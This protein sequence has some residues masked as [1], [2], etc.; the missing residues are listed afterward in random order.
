MAAGF[1]SGV[2]CLRNVG[3]HWFLLSSHS[4]ISV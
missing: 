3:V 4:I 1:L 2:L